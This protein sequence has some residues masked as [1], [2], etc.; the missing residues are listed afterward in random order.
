[1]LRQRRL[2]TLWLSQVLSSIGDNL[3]EIA[4]LFAPL[5]VMIAAGAFGLLRF[6][7]VAPPSGQAMSGERVS[8]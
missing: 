6:G 4:T 3:F 8:G 2:A 7:F 5:P 1:M